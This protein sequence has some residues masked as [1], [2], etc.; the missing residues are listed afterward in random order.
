MHFLRGGAIVVVV[1]GGGHSFLLSRGVG[2]GEEEG[3]FDFVWCH[4]TTRAVIKEG[5]EGGEDIIEF[6][7]EK[8]GYLLRT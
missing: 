8:H 7:A 5:S 2:V 6:R 1:E 4:P 3:P